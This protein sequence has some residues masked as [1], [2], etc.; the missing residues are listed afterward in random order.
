[1]RKNDIL[2]IA[3]Q[4]KSTPFYKGPPVVLSTQV[5][6]GGSEEDEPVGQD[7]SA[8]AVQGLRVFGSVLVPAPA[9]QQTCSFTNIGVQTNIN[10]RFYVMACNRSGN[11]R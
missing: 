8:R 11:T 9:S 10:T 7:G 2:H 5:R 1:M 4:N 3:L 6:A